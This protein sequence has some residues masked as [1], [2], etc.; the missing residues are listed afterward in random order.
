M[1]NLFLL[2][3]P[4][5]ERGCVHGTGAVRDLIDRPYSSDTCVRIQVAKEYLRLSSFVCPKL[6]ITS[7]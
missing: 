1:I 2:A 3:D 6:N 7:V 4:E 5:E